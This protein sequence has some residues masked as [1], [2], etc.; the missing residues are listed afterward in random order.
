MKTEF[1][2]LIVKLSAVGDIVHT[3]PALHALRTQFPTARIGWVAHPGPAQLLEDHPQLDFLFKLPRPRSWRDAMR[4]VSEWREVLR[5]AGAWDVAIDF[6][7]LTKSGLVAWLSGAQKRIGF[8]G[9]ASRELN[10]LFVNERIRP[11]AHEVIR[12]N[13]ELLRPLGCNSHEARALLISHPADDA[14]IEQWATET[15]NVGR[16]FF[17]I[18]A[19]AGWPT[20]RWPLDRWVTVACGVHE[21]FGFEIMVFYGPGEEMEAKEFLALLTRVKVPATLAP[22]TTLRQ[23]VALLR[24][25]GGLFGGGDTGPM[26]IAAALGIPTVALFGSSDSRRNAPVFSGANFEVI[27]DFT[28][29]CAGTFW[30]KCPYHAPGHCLDAI[31]PPQVLEA[32]KRVLTRCGDH[33]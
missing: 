4:T 6:Q 28:R 30:R 32:V 15:H 21:A 1:H 12:M 27:Q 11:V 7:G 2:I 19:F 17:V 5:R 10:A 9:G 29:P 20:K 14:Y 8:A 31:L 16:K 26:H 3:L 23:Y 13:L 33:E 24:H 25:H 18:D 22:P